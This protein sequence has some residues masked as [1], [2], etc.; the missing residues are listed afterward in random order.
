MIENKIYTNKVFKLILRYR[1][2]TEKK[3]GFMPFPT[4]PIELNRTLNSAEGNEFR[5]KYGEFIEKFG[6]YYNPGFSYNNI[7]ENESDLGWNKLLG[8]IKKT[9]THENTLSVIKNMKA[10]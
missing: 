1:K 4:S 2:N 6:G 7:F 9:P 5:V 8:I 3:D 10:K